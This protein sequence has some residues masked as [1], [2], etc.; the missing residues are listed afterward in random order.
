MPTTE[1]PTIVD[2]EASGSGQYDDL[3]SPAWRIL[4]DDDSRPPRGTGKRSDDD[5]DGDEPPRAA[6]GD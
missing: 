5:S 1:L 2:V 4:L 3:E 6:A